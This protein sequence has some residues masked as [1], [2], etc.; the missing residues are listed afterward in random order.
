[1]P[2]GVDLLTHFVSRDHLLF[3]SHVLASLV[4]STLVFLLC[5]RYILFQLTQ[6]F[7]LST[8]DMVEFIFSFPLTP[9]PA[10]WRVILSAAPPLDVKFSVT[11]NGCVQVSLFRLRSPTTDKTSRRPRNPSSSRYV[12]SSDWCADMFVLG[13]HFFND[14]AVMT[15]P[16]FNIT[17]F[18]VRVDDKN[19]HK[20]WA[21]SNTC[22]RSKNQ[23]ITHRD[24]TPGGNSSSRVMA[25]RGNRSGHCT[26][27]R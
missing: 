11:G 7:L 14:G 4:T 27:C 13:D 16:F 23:N 19:W 3:L 8:L 24:L 12:F 1:M 20:L 18:R 15:T 21:P 26:I 5:Y 22:K 2:T 9:L 10:Q 6:I 17:G 25:L